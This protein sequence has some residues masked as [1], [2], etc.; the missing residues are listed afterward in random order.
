MV[1]CAGLWRTKNKKVGRSLTVTA[2]SLQNKH[3]QAGLIC[4]PALLHFQKKN[5]LE[6]IPAAKCQ[7]KPTQRRLDYHFLPNFISNYSKIKQKMKLSQVWMETAERPE[8][9][10]KLSTVTFLSHVFWS[11]KHPMTFKIKEVALKKLNWDYH[12]ENEQRSMQ[13][14]MF[15]HSFRPERC[16]AA[17]YQRRRCRSHCTKPAAP[18]LWECPHTL[19]R[20][21]RTCNT[22]GA[23][24]RDD[25]KTASAEDPDEHL[26]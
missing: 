15:A 16:T 18:F 19:C 2:T 12:G 17:G 11:Y 9:R 22:T 6:S 1:Y 10:K 5:Q 4:L 7:S 21:C 23:Q 13:T 3:R 24:V 14:A 25:T 20:R 8:V 26:G